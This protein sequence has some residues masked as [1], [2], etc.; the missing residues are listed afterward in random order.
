VSR[1]GKGS[2]APDRIEQTPSKKANTA[3]RHR[4]RFDEEQL[5][6][7]DSLS[8]GFQRHDSPNPAEQG[9][10]ACFVLRDD[11][12]CQESDAKGFHDVLAVSSGREHVFT[13]P[14]P[15][16]AQKAFTAEHA[17]DTGHP[18]PCSKQESRK[19]QSVLPAGGTA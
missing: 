9:R 14:T 16:R 18:F 17:D 8:C 15:W 6:D 2:A 4:R 7:I 10:K 13:A 1:A 12:T 11:F 5:K 19:A 3:G